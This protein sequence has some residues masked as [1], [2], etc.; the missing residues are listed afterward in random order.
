M[1]KP[2]LWSLD[3]RIEYE[4]GADAARRKLSFREEGGTS[5]H[6]RGRI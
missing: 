3:N 4:H 1:S 5:E 6:E 2:W